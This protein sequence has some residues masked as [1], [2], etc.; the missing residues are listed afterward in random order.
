MT[1]ILTTEVSTQEDGISIDDE[2]HLQIPVM[3][4]T[5]SES[6]DAQSADNE[7][8]LI[9]S[10]LSDDDDIEIEENDDE[11]FSLS[12][13][14]SKKYIISVEESYSNYYT[15]EK[16]TS[17]ILTKFE[18]AKLLGVRSEMISAGNPPLVIVPKGVDNAYEIALLELTEKKIP[19]I[20]RRYMPN[21]SIEDWRVEELI[22]KHV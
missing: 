4:T 11:N 1:D 9:Q 14:D 22:I 17:P 2:S 21:G 12:N 7:S 20:I 3:S 6:I 8:S 19:L 16:K 18:R 10:I 15:N 13:K 5:D